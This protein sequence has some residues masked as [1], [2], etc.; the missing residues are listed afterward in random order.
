MHQDK[1]QWPK[2]DKGF[3]LL[4]P[5]PKKRGMGRQRKNRIPS[6]LEKGKGKATRQVQCPDCQQF[7]YRKG[8]VRCELTGTRKRKRNKKTKTNVGRKRAKGA[9]DAQ[10]TAVDVQANTRRTRAAAAKEAAAESQVHAT[11]T[12]SP[13]PINRR[14]W[15]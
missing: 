6:A 13:G 8:S 15:H 4:P 9:I 11:Q 3:K 10:A 2:V 1:K 5:V 12:S 7:G 14:G